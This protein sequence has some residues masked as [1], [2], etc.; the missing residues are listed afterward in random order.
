MAIKFANYATTELSGSINS[1][2]TSVSVV[3][4]AVFPSITNPDYFY[5]TLEEGSTREIVKVTARSGNTLTVVR[6]QDGTS[7]S[8]FTTAAKVELRLAKATI[9]DALNE[10]LAASRISYGTADPTGGSDGDIYFK[11]YV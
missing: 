7:G 1:T 4:G 11:Y 2:T 3:D 6:G 10:R 5:V 8:S 9:E